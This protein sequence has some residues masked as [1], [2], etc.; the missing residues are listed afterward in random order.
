MVRCHV[1][2]GHLSLREV[3]ASPLWPQ[4]VLSLFGG[5][6]SPAATFTCVLL[7]GRRCLRPC[8][9]EPSFPS[10]LFPSERRAG[11]I[12]DPPCP[13]S[14][15]FPHPAGACAR[16][17]RGCRMRPIPGECTDPSAVCGD[18]A[19]AGDAAV[20]PRRCRLVPARL[21]LPG[22][23]CSV[24]RVRGF[25]PWA[26]PASGRAPFCS[27]LRLRTGPLQKAPAEAPL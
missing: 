22:L 25:S 19:T 11:W 1:L 4:G 6:P 8:F 27:S 5:Q 23:V 26:S 18:G 9:S 16:P 10:E 24:F 17:Q 15:S 21:S 20:S 3:G 13:W 2:S 7:G 14:S 12:E